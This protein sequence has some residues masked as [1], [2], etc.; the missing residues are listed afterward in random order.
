MSP[1]SVLV[2]GCWWWMVY[3][4][5]SAW[6][7]CVHT[8]SN[9]IYQPQQH[10]INDQQSTHLTSSS[11][12]RSAAERPATRAS[13]AMIPY[14]MSASQSRE[15]ACQIR[16]CCFCALGGVD[17][18]VGVG[19]VLYSGDRS[20][21]TI[22]RSNPSIPT[23]PSNHIHRPLL[24]LQD[25]HDLGPVHPPLC[26]Q[27]REGREEALR[28]RLR[29]RAEEHQVDVGRRGQPPRCRRRCRR[30]CLCG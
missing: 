8:G 29:V 11:P 25:A 19:P 21:D 27:R 16:L 22:D 7:L 2:D 12:S 1:V 20:S 30:S 10:H 15:R 9:P 17:R 6:M 18:C 26:L 14:E 13:A 4:M 3:E 23:H 24:D 5:G 28:A